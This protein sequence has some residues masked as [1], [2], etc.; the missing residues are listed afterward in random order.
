MD[1][2]TQFAS[3]F[4]RLQSSPR[5][6]FRPQIVLYFTLFSPDSRFLQVFPARWISHSRYP[7]IPQVFHPGLN[8]NAFGCVR[9]ERNTFVI[10]IPSKSR[11][12]SQC[13]ENEFPRDSKNLKSGLTLSFRPSPA[14]LKRPP[15]VWETSIWC[16]V[17]MQ[18]WRKTLE[19]MIGDYL[20]IF[21]FVC[22][23][24]SRETSF[25]LFRT[26]LST[27]SVRETSRLL[28]NSRDINAI[29]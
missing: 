22:F 15:A 21:P 4:P 13:L 12:N 24:V 6:W 28:T 3:H 7:L 5:L 16:E 18:K 8:I 17:A 20:E 26:K 29:N 14:E 19:K 1:R 25:V 10:E 11:L 23:R 27:N 9:M 2:S